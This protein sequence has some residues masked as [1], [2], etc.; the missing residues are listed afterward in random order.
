MYTASLARPDT[1]LKGLVELESRCQDVTQEVKLLCERQ[2]VLAGL[3]EDQSRLQSKATEKYDETIFE[4]MRELEEKRSQKKPWY[5]YRKSTFCH[6]VKVRGIE[7]ACCK[8]WDGRERPRDTMS[9]EPCSSSMAGDME[10]VSS[11][12]SRKMKDMEETTPE[13]WW[14]NVTKGKGQEVWR[15]EPEG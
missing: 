12:S 2:E 11:E 7:R 10:E 8:D 5:L 1:Q 6:G 14:K 4:E 15:L 13:A 9:V 3:V